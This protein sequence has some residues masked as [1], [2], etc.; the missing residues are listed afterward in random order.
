M[1]SRNRKNA[2]SL[3]IAVAFVLGYFIGNYFSTNT[4]ITYSYT[5]PPNAV[6]TFE[7][8][9]KPGENI[10]F[11]SI[12]VP[13]VDEN[14]NGIATILSV[15]VIPGSG[16]VLANIDKL[17]FWTDTQNSIRTARS[18]AANITGIDLSTYDIIYTIQ[19]NAS[20]VEGPSAGSA[21]TVATIAALKNKKVNQSVMMTGTINHDGTIGPVGNILEK[22][23]A[24]K[25][26]GAELF[27]VPLGSSVQTTYKTEKYCE[28]IGPTQICT[29][30]SIPQKIEVSKAIGIEV[31]E[32]IS[33]EEALK[34]FLI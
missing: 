29:T 30:E 1:K 6:T 16:K 32:I 21:L 15:Q 23:N 17:L 5:N 10:S 4:T 27:L 20:A 34:Y 12:R 31:K 25:Q 24:S 9:I 22:A 19:A 26:I 18:V 2:T 13:A 33:V 7:P 11:A 3:I 8:Y 14:G 28:Q